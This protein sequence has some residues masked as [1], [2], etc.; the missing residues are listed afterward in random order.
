MV[1]R[2]GALIWQGRLG[3]RGRL[4]SAK[5][6]LYARGMRALTCAL[7]FL[8]L[9][10]GAG[11]S[12]GVIAAV[13]DAGSGG[14]P[15]AGADLAVPPPPPVASGCVDSVTAG[16]HVYTCDGL[17]V[18]AT[19]P[20]TCL[21]PGCGL[22][23][24]LHGDTGTG[25]FMD[26][27][28]NLRAL[29]RQNG[30]VVLA[31]TGPPFGN[32][33]PGSTWTPAEDAKILAM[34]RLV[35]SVF[36]VDAKRIHLTGFSRGGFVTWRLLCDA[37]DLFA[38]VAPAAAGEGSSFGEVTCFGNGRAPKR[39]ADIL[40]LLGRTDMSVP[41]STMASIRDG[42]ITQYGGANKQVLKSDANYTHNRWTSPQG[43]VIETFDHA[44]ETVADGPFGSARGHCFPG[45]K[46][47]PYAA[48]YAV[49]CKAP[50]AFTWGDEV[51]KFFLA[52][53][54]K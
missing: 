28:T 33:Y 2:A 10:A 5:A 41:Y 22:I 29:A 7:P 43:A 27:H 40:F 19:I 16:D 45:S 8:L 26:G 18:D 49:P 25:L 3:I 32:P 42:A 31:P 9:V 44:Y 34:T 6:F 39:Q 36:R 52:H 38:S 20:P 12:T 46:T 30:Y 1:L 51:M 14:L 53:P 37:A 50:N 35:A 54:M 24:E 17:R 21:A 15:D 11:C 13:E 47:D 23:V 4:R 48:Q